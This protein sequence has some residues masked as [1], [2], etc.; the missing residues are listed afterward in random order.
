MHETST[1]AVTPMGSSRRTLA[2]NASFLLAGQVVTSA[3]SVI[4]IALLGRW[5]GAVEFGV[6]YLLSVVAN[7]AYVFV[8]WGQT[9]YLIRESARRRDDSGEL[10]GAALALRAII[11]FV[12]AVATVVLARAIGYDRRTEFLALLAVACGL[13]LALSQAYVYMFRGRDRMDLDATVTITGKALTVLVT[14]PA[15][16][17]GGGLSAVL[18]MQAVG[19]AGALLMA[20]LL[21]H[22]IPIKARPPRYGVMRELVRGGAPLAVL[23]LTLA[24]QPFIDVIVL[25]KLVPA[26]VVGWYGAA[27][28]IIGVLFASAAILCN[29]SFPELSRVSNSVQELRSSLRATSRLLLLLGALAAVGTFLFANV[30]VRLFYGR[31]HFDPAITVLQFFAP[32]L[33]LLFM[34]MLFG[35]A[36]TAVGKTKEIAVVKVVNVAISTGLAILLI[37]ICQ[38]R[39][40]NGGLGLVLAF[41]SSEILMLMAILWLLPRG[42]VDRSALLN[43]LRAVA[44]AGGTV[45]I[46]WTLPSVTPWIAVPASFAVFVPV[47]LASGLILRTDL[48]K[49]ATLVRG[50]IDRL[51]FG[52]KG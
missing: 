38:A 47:A 13:P 51:L 39:L 22:K 33:P 15:L 42:A 37:P 26:E 31:G 14:I 1:R 12:V 46:I 16:F 45:L 35:N 28:N 43:F 41:G 21:E 3:L 50:Q 8:D 7:F 9:A 11:A 40:G 49:V 25:T 17:L 52:A 36:I 44:T 6:Y 48:D 10:L 20:G 29:A 2:R 5:L 34:D 18:I 23:F 24:V 32:A 30:A 27:R 4:L 19:G